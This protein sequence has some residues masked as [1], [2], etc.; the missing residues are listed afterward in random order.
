MPAKRGHTGLISKLKTPLFS[1]SSK[2]TGQLRKFEEG[3]QPLRQ[4]LVQYCH[5]AQDFI[6]W[7]LGKSQSFVRY[8]HNACWGTGG[9]LDT[10]LQSKFLLLKVKKISQVF[11]T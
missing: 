8:L 7:A 9:D 2:K 11:G 4:W 3:I 5:V 1:K 6:L 10:D